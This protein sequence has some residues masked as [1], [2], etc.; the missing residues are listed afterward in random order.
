VIRRALLAVAL[1]AGL[2]S[3][4][5]EIPAAAAQ[6]PATI[7]IRTKT[8]GVGAHPVLQWNR[9]PGA[10]RYLLSVNTTHGSPYWSWTGSTTKVRFGGG[11][12]A[13]SGRGATGAALEHKMRWFVIAFDDTGNIVA[14][15]KPH[16]IAP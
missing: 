3:A 1:S 6:H 9:V 16:A 10:R 4:L 14:V 2:L 15:S 5:P 8:H 7:T 12:L 13:S 11:P